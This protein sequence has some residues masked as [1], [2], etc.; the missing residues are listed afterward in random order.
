MNDNIQ[1]KSYQDDLADDNTP[2]PFTDE[3]GDDPSAELGIPPEE[4]KREL[5]KNEVD[6]LQEGD[7]EE[8]EDEREDRGSYLEDID[9]D[10]DDK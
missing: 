3:S 7:F 4:L 10:G 9:E 6:D 2:D 1:L 8:D 5:D